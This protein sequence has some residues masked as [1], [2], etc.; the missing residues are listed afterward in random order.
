MKKSGKADAEAL[1]ALP[2]VSGSIEF[3]TQDQQTAAQKVVGDRWNA[4]ISG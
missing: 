2:E 1:K 3:P 4:E